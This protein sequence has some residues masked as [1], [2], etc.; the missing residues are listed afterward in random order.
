MEP[1]VP[2]TS[3]T[4]DPPCTPSLPPP[5]PL[6]VDRYRQHHS[7]DYFRYPPGCRGDEEGRKGGVAK[8]EEDGEE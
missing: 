6:R 4:T 5:L 7:E 2:A 3:T 1:E 8:D